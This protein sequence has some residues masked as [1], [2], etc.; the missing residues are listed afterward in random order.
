MKNV[1]SYIKINQPKKK[2]SRFTKKTAEIVKET[3][4]K[5]VKK[6]AAKKTSG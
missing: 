5:A 2:G 3:P 4:K 1:V 6:P